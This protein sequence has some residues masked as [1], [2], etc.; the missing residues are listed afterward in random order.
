MP[1]MSDEDL[2]LYD[3]IKRCELPSE[4]HKGN[5]KYFVPEGCLPLVVSKEAIRWELEDDDLEWTQDLDGLVEFIQSRAM[6]VFAIAVRHVGLEPS[7]LRKAM[8]LFRG[9]PSGAF[10]DDCLPVRPQEEGKVHVLANFDANIRRP[11]WTGPRIDTFCEYQWRF[12]SPILHVATE[13]KYNHDFAGACIM[14]FTKLCAA[15]FDRGAFG[16]V[17]KYAI[18]PNHLHDPEKSVHHEFV[19]VK[20][21]QPRSERDRQAMVLNWEHEAGILQKMNALQQEHIVRFL[22]AFRHGDEGKKSHYLM[23]EWADGGNLLSMWKTL[24]PPSTPKLVKA[25]VKQIMGLA[26]ALCVAHYPKSGPTFRHGDLKPAN[27]LWFR[28][29][30]DSSGIGTLKIADWG[31]AKE[32]NTVTELR[33]HNTSTEYGTRRYE[34][35]EEDTGLGVSLQNLLP[36]GQPVKKAGKRRSRLYDIWSMGCITLEF[37]VWMLD[38]HVGLRRFNKEVCSEYTECCPFYQTRMENGIKVARVHDAAVRWMERMAMDP[39]C[40]VGETALGDLLE[41]VQTR[42]LV[43]ALPSRLGTSEWPST[44]GPRSG[45]L[46]G[47]SAVP[48]LLV[49]VST[50]LSPPTGI[51]HEL[52]TPLSPSADTSPSPTTGIPKIAISEAESPPRSRPVPLPSP[53]SILGTGKG[54]ALADEFAERMDQIYLEADEDKGYWISGISGSTP[55]LLVEEPDDDE[56]QGSSWD[57]AL[58]GQ[59]SGLPQPSQTSSTGTGGLTVPKPDKFD[60]GN[61]D[62]DNNWVRFVDNEFAPDISAARA[63]ASPPRDTP[64]SNLCTTCQALRDGLWRP[65]F[66]QAYK[67]SDLKTAFKAKSCDLCGLLWLTCERLHITKGPDVLVT[68]EGSY[69]KMNS[70][71]EPALAVLR[72]PHLKTPINDTIQVGFPDQIHAASPDTQFDIIKKWLLHCDTEHNCCSQPPQTTA[73]PIT[74]QTTSNHHLPTRLIAVGQASDTHVRLIETQPASTGR[75]L[76]LSHQWGPGP[77]FFTTRSNLPSHLRGIPLTDLPA[78]FRDAV[79][80]TRAVGY[81]YLWIDSLCIVQGP[82]GDFNQEAKRMEQVYSGAA[83]VLAVSRGTGHG[84]GFLGPRM[85]RE[86]VAMRRDGD[87]A[88]FYVCGNVDDFNAHVLEGRLSRRGWVLQEHA[89]ARRTVFFTDWQMYWECG[90]GVRCET[91]VRMSK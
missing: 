80:V 83:C 91:M 4:F 62:L 72:N 24:A 77:H 55:F 25:A 45:G 59:M 9:G 10:T 41:L 79:R 48:G 52:A 35:P 19:A 37:I 18:H 70:L 42:L 56:S 54:R 20:A 36:K 61:T 66:S 16:E 33:T 22:T 26:H 73:P 1:N 3:R 15:G 17:S 38:G 47:P 49:P 31:L 81:P 51:V 23:F 63:A 43:V 5:D 60:Y 34:P 84:S 67:L 14:P 53:E 8:M 75:W 71:P 76:A 50:Q 64:T 13:T 69:L 28:D 86:Y 65:A 39:R 2:S 88:E 46:L 40:K 21:I 11:I 58:S 87:K 82:H 85:G 74:T 57:T 6:K 12:L 78:T 68:R 44:T 30:D 27:I 90:Q 89:L 29:H 7:T 32:Q